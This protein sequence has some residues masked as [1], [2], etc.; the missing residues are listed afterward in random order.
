M[1]FPSMSAVLTMSLF[2]I[3]VL[4]IVAKSKERGNSYEED[5]KRVS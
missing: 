2:I 4:M 3:A 5:N 1:V